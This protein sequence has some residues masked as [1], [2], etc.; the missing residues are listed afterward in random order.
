MGDHSC[1]INKCH[2]RICNKKKRRG[3]LINYKSKWPEARGSCPTE[4]LATQ[5]RAFVNT[6][7]AQTQKESV[8]SV[9]AA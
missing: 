9:Q 1:T 5:V 4:P 3:N 6:E 7:D 8:S 2:S